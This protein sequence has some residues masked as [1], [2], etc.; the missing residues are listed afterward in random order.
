MIVVWRGFPD[1]FDNDA[2][3]FVATGSKDS[4][5]LHH[6]EAADI[7]AKLVRLGSAEGETKLLIWGDSHAMAILP[8]IE[9]LCLEN[10]TV[11]YAATRYATAPAVEYFHKNQDRQRQ[12]IVKFNA[13]V[14]EYVQSSRIPAVLLVGRWSYYEDFPDRTLADAL[15]QTIDSL[16]ACGCRVY[17]MKD[18]PNY[19]FDVPSAMVR[20]TMETS[21]VA[22]SSEWVL[23]SMREQMRGR[24][25]WFHV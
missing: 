6:L 15:L 25:C 3:R 7:P 1:R 18:V 8:V 4:R 24:S 20:N 16:V 12:G 17:F 11:A 19:H 23:K 13:A 10:G 9:S 2:R 21:R 5:Y 22:G 14:V